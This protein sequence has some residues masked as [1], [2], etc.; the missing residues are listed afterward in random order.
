MLVKA[1]K[2]NNTCKANL[3]TTFS[4]NNKL[5]R[6]DISSVP[7]PSKKV[8]L[9]SSNGNHGK[10]NHFTP[11]PKWSPHIWKQLKQEKSDQSDDHGC[12]NNDGSGGNPVNYEPLMA[13]MTRWHL[14]IAYLQVIQSHLAQL[15]GHLISH[16]NA[17][18]LIRMVG[19]NGENGPHSWPCCKGE[20]GQNRQQKSHFGSGRST[21]AVATW[22]LLHSKT[23]SG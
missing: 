14:K 18:S 23:S 13:A 19:V 10:I 2:L 6:H 21:T 15:S 22:V 17:Q 4:A 3:P 5:A 9:I 8:G 20:A 1:R 11:G 7:L 12:E 16:S